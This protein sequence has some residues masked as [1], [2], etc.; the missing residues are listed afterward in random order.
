MFMRGYRDAASCRQQTLALIEHADGDLGLPFSP[1]LWS[2][3]ICRA[4]RYLRLCPTTTSGGEWGDPLLNHGTRPSMAY[5]SL[6]LCEKEDIY[7]WRKYS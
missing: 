6:D 7:E 4:K 5:V 1:S 3:Q 2:T